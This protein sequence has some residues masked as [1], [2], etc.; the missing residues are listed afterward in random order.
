MPISSGNTDEGVASPA[1]L[2]FTP[3]NWNTPQTVTV[4]GVDDD[5]EDGDVDYTIVVGAATSSDP[6]YD[7]YD[8]RDV[9]VVNKDNE[10]P[11]A[12][13]Y[14]SLADSANLPGIASA[15]SGADIVGFTGSDFFMWFD[16]SDVGVGGLTINAFAFAGPGEI[17]M[18]FT[19]AAN[20]PGVGTVDDS[21][22]VK[23]TATSL[24]EDTAGAFSLYFDGSDVGL[25]TSSEDI[26]GLELLDDGRLLISTSGS[27]S[28]PGVSAA[29]QDVLI[30][31]P[32]SLGSTTAGSW[33]MYFDGS[34][35][36]LSSSS[37]IVDAVASGPTG[38]LMLSTTGNFSVS[39]ASGA[40]EDILEFT[41][42]SLGSNTAGVFS[43][44]FDG[45]LYGLGPEDVRG[46]DFPPPPPNVPP[47][48][49]AGGPYATSEG[50]SVLL[51]AAGT[52]DPDGSIVVYA[53]D[54]DNDGQF[55]DAFGPSAHFNTTGDG[56]H[57]VGL[58][59]TDDRGDSLRLGQP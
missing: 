7:G 49:E 13:L 8:G 28:V 18:S 58:Q 9:A 2:T 48:A 39:G 47:I 26:E 6:D 1:S 37:E 34:D 55:D 38:H 40:N 42:T 30:F 17:L 50:S 53:W 57:A 14:I 21:D 56:V 59:V 44:L 23:F 11:E 33:A 19:A 52:Y 10:Q 41:P 46:L 12:L 16:G 24:G 5:E 31:T 25:S 3:A 51:S 20:I 27:A 22:I 36:A 45:S 29:G 43:L 32:T 35:V 4:T 15:V 54:L